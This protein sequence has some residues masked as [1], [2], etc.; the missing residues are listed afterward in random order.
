MMA[1]IFRVHMSM[2]EMDKQMFNIQKKHSSYVADWL[3]NNVKLVVCDIPP[4][5]GAN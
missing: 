1:A 5:P 3:P 4:H 2:K